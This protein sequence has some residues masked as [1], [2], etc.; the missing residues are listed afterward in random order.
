MSIVFV[1]FLLPASVHSLCIFCCLPVSTLCI[2]SVA[3]QCLLFVYFLLPASVYSL[4]IFCC[5]PVS[6][7]CISIRWIEDGQ[8]YYNPEWSLNILGE[9]LSAILKAMKV[10]EKQRIN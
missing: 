2:F 8:G 5:L 9:K 7:L 10:N 1:Y 4:C 6:T 3:C